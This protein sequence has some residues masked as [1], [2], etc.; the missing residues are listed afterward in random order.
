MVSYSKQPRIASL[1]S[2]D[3]SNGTR[4][5]KVSYQGGTGAKELY[6]RRKMEFDI[7]EKSFEKEDK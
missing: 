4:L 2:E 7:F 6:E 1:E 3:Q 5:V